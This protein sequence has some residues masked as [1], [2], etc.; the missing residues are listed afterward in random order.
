MIGTPAVKS[1]IREGKVH[2]LTSIIQTSQKY[3]MQHMDQVLKSMVN[4]GKID[5]QE[6]KMYSANPDLFDDHISRPR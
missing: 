5:V 6:A 1:L 2:Q 4:M 3:G